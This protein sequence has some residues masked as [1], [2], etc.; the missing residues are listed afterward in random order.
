[1]KIS[2]ARTAA[3]DVLMKIE[4]EKAFSSHLLAAYEENLSSKDRALCH[5]L[6]LGVLRRQ[7]YLDRIIDNLAG[8]KRLDAAV[9]IALRI[10]LYQ[11]N[12]LDRVP[13]H[14]AINESVN[15]VLRARKTSAKSLVNAVLRRA[16]REEISLD[17]EDEFERIS[18]ETSHPVWLLEKWAGEFGWDEAARLTEANNQVPRPAFRFITKHHITRG[19]ENTEI[20]E[21]SYQSEFVRDCFIVEKTDERLRNAAM[22]GDIYFQD[23]ASQM[24]AAAVRL[25]P[26]VRFL[27][28]CASPGSKTTK[29]AW[30]TEVQRVEEIIASIKVKTKAVEREAVLVAGDLSWK[31]IEF[32]RENCRNQDVG[33]VNIVQ[34]DAERALPFANDAF[35]TV[36]VDA[37]CSGTGTIRHNPEIRYFLQPGDFAELQ[38]KQ[39]R[40][41]QNASKLVNRGGSLTYSTCSLEKE[42]NEMVCEAFL[43]DDRDFRLIKPNVPERFL[44][45]LGFARTFPQKD[46]MD[47]FFIAAFRKDLP[48]NNAKRRE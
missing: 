7:I 34:Y 14:S 18:V 36:L 24:V 44:T 46:G 1:M 20:H 35:D 41:L 28:V 33:F 17:F 10:G 5:E 19:G 16:T 11:I 39:L 43:R 15:L 32:L 26:G 3:F 29:V 23:E 38:R 9:R 25:K 6:V 21:S 48:A 8:G 12:F 27:D 40:I 31:R 4:T 13:H 22:R 2:P 45:E 47:G 42:E 30:D 37:P